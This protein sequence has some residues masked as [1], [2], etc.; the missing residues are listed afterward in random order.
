MRIIAA[1]FFFPF[2]FVLCLFL[3]FVS[4]FKK[5]LFLVDA[6]SRGWKKGVERAKKERFFRGSSETL[7]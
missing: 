4:I 2:V 3:G 6:F 5:T 1:V 7:H